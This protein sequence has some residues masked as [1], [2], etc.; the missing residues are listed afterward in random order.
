MRLSKK[1]KIVLLGLAL[2]LI[3]CY[4]FAVSKTLAYYLQYREQ[5]RIVSN[6]LQNPATLKS[7]LQKEK[8]LNTVLRE[9]NVVA[10]KSFQ[11]DLLKQVSALSKKH[12][13]KITEFKEPHTWTDKDT[14]TSS[15]GFAVEGSFNGALLLINKLENSPSVGFIKHIEFIKKRNYKTNSDY[16]ITEILLQKS[17]SVS[18]NRSENDQAITPLNTN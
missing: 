16:L 6:N 2:V 1:N 14:K 7:L 12:N 17:E 9:Y 4:K 8:Q 10:D 15:Y 3:L 13:L 5:K 11:N 18:K